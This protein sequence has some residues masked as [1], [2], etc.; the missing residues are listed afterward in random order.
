MVRIEEDI[1]QLQEVR[2]P[3]TPSTTASEAVLP[4]LTEDP[5]FAERTE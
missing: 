2:H 1:Q 4:N 3:W 5:V